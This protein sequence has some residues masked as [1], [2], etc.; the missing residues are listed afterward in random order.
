MGLIEILG[1][2]N[3]IIAFQAIFLLV[4]FTLKK[5]GVRL[6][7]N[8]LAI[9]TGA[10]G[11]VA[12]NTF[13][14]LVQYELRSDVFQEVANQVMW[15]IAPSLYLYVAYHESPFK[16]KRVYQHLLPYL[17]VIAISAVFNSPAY[18]N[19]VIIVAFV[20]M[21]IYLYLGIR[22]AVKNYRKDRQFYSWV[23]P[24]LIVFSVLVLVNVLVK[25]LVASGVLSFSQE[26]LQGFTVLL[27]VPVFYTSY[28]E[29]N[30][31]KT[32]TARYQ[33]TPIED[34][35]SEDIL[36]AV[37]D[38]LVQRKGFSDKGLTMQ[39]VSEKTGIPPR[40]I[41]QV[42]NSRLGMSFSDYINQLRI[43]EVTRGLLDESKAHLTIAGI[44]EEAGFSSISRFNHLFKKTMGLTPRAYQKAC[45]EPK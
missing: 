31:G 45:S 24:M 17:P 20:Q 4:H 38:Y 41:S 42:I 10:F 23:L 8:L 37:Q 30:A 40:Y 28:R 9:C 29:M 27:S 13:F 5:K 33:T 44:A 21:I 35:K 7:N 39:V 18:R 22:K 2:I 32:V 3:L 12:L 34:K 25:T 15:F 6:L 16:I 43:E 11:L 1:L 14:S 26:L 19:T 36:E